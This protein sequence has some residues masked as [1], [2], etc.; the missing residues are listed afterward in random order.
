MVLGAGDEGGAGFFPGGGWG[1]NKGGGS[2][3]SGR[4]GDGFGGLQFCYQLEAVSFVQMYPL[5]K[6]GCGQPYAESTAVSSRDHLGALTFLGP[7]AMLLPA[8]GSTSVKKA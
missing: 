1:G 7:S 3:G 5:V 8:E 2:P 4:E 6:I